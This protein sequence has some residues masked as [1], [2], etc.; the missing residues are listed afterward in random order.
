LI[1]IHKNIQNILL[2]N[3]LIFNWLVRRDC[4]LKHVFVLY[5]STRWTL[6]F[7]TKFCH[8]WRTN[9]IKLE[10]FNHHHLTVL[11]DKSQEMVH[12]FQKKFTKL[13]LQV[14]KHCHY[15]KSWAIT[16]WEISIFRSRTSSISSKVKKDLSWKWVL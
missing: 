13:C 2:G 4:W 8:I 5:Q 6:V 11:G 7:N 9:Q 15:I 14:F 12:S 3:I 1:P 16:Y 10:L